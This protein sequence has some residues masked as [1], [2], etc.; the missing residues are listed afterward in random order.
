MKKI[1][2]WLIFA[3]WLQAAGIWIPSILQVIWWRFNSWA[4]LSAWIAN[5][6]MSWLVVWV[7]PALGVLPKLPDYQQFWMLAG[8]VALVYVPIMFLTKPDDMDHLVRYYVAARPCGF[9]GP[10][11]REA[12]KRGLIKVQE[13]EQ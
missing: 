13:R 8:L 10:V 7:L 6:M 9:W 3:L 5:L 1:T 2:E 11:R 12:I 4:Y